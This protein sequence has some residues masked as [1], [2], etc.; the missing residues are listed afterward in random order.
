[1]QMFTPKDQINDVQPAL[2]MLDN[3]VNESQIQLTQ[4]LKKNKPI[5][6]AQLYS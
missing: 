5:H 1:M 2:T 4:V 3:Q 6:A